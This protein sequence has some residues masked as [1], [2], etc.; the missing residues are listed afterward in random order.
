M[1]TLQ[2]EAKRYWSS[3]S[4]AS[5]PN[6]YDSKGYTLVFAHALG[7]HK[8]QCEPM[9]GDLYHLLPSSTRI[10]EV[11]SVDAPHCGEAAEL[12]EEYL[13][14]GYDEMFGWQEYARALHAFLAGLGTGVDVDF[15]KRRLVFVGH[16]LG[17]I[18]Q[19]LS[20]TYQPQLN[21]EIMILLEMPSHIPEDVRHAHNY[22]ADG[23]EK[24]RDIWPSREAAFELFNSRGAWKS[25]DPRVL[26]LFVDHSLRAL[27]SLEYPDRAGV[28]LR[29]TRRQETAT[30]RD[31]HG[32][33]VIYVTIG[34]IAK[35]VPIH[36]VYGALM[37]YLPRDR[38]DD[39][40]AN[41]V[42]GAEKLG[43]LRWVDGA[44]HQRHAIAAAG[45]NTEELRALNGAN[46]SFNAAH[47]L[48]VYYAGLSEA[49]IPDLLARMDLPD[50]EVDLEFF[51]RK[52][53]PVVLCLQGIVHLDSLKDLPSGPSPDLWA[54]V[55]PWIQFLDTHRVNLPRLAVLSEINPMLLV[56][57]LGKD[58]AT[59]VLIRA[60]PGLR[61]FICR[62]WA[63]SF[64]QAQLVP[65]PLAGAF[66][67]ICAYMYNISI[68]IAAE[69]EFEEAIQGS[70]GSKTSLARL[71]VRHI[72]MCLLKSKSN[73]ISAWSIRNVFSFAQARCEVDASFR[74][75]LIDEGIVPTLTAVACRLS[76]PPFTTDDNVF[77]GSW[78]IRYYLRTPFGH[79]IVTAALRAGLLHAML[80]W[81]RLS[82]SKPQCLDQVDHILIILSQSL[83]YLSVLLQLKVSNTELETPLDADTFQRLPVSEKWE[84]FWSLLQERWAFMTEYLERDKASVKSACMACCAI[85]GK[86]E[87]QRCSG[88]RSFQYC[89]RA[90]QKHDWRQGGHREACSLRPASASDDIVVSRRDTSF[91]RALLHEDYLRMRARLLHDELVYL[92]SNPSARGYL[93][94]K[95]D[96]CTPYVGCLA[97]VESEE[98]F[99]HLDDEVWLL[100]KTKA[101]ASDGR[102]QTHV[103]HVGDGGYE[104]VRMFPLYAAAGDRRKGVEMLATETTGAEVDEEADRMQINRL[105]ELDILEVHL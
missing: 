20:L 81:G 4:D 23:S 88:C 96:Y 85:K 7:F 33:F 36:L 66:E 67:I 28:T 11:W 79:S 84:A 18:A 100:Q 82:L 94:Y 93:Y 32:P 70:G 54:R 61:I 68:T 97:S 103:M 14:W 77:N 86:S 15:T 40:I 26:R 6:A 52:L 91:L 69:H 90:C 76:A 75:I 27:P 3:T 64:D 72:E 44:G 24:R 89:S 101:R 30:Y 13:R 49:S 10:H 21:P 22:L 55:W 41:G 56:L 65:T 25:W 43:S 60:T 62:V 92:R 53:S 95:F 46:G 31:K 16:S 104:T 38:I 105:A 48:P 51:T 35:R 63:D 37:D 8:E 78:A 83:V 34:S 29:C 57:A 58:T 12:N 9:I 80:A 73:T 71:C 39:F 1:A 45:G 98:A 99:A 5:S 50:A 19:V 74:Q 2:P 47:L 42:G 87:L 59:A 102:V 17:A